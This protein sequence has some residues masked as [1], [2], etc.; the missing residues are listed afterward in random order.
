MTGIRDRG[1]PPS[2]PAAFSMSACGRSFF[3]GC[4]RA[5]AVRRTAVSG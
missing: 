5:Q 1:G 4:A 2:G 3:C